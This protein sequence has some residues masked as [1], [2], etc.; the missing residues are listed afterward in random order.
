ML[1]M[2]SIGSMGIQP[3]HPQPYSSGRFDGSASTS[4]IHGGI[5]PSDRSGGITSQIALWQV[6]I[7][8]ALWDIFW[9]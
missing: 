6:R 7:V 4:H 5:L 8:R 3:G 2:T 1:G 9:H